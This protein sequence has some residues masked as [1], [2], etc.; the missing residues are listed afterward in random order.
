MNQMEIETTDKNDKINAELQKL[1]AKQVME[2]QKLEKISKE[3][4]FIETDL[5]S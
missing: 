5:K 2:S 4:D 1:I 3:K